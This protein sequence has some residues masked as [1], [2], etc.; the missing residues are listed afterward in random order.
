MAGT[1]SSA[2][3]SKYLGCSAPPRATTASMLFSDKLADTSCLYAVGAAGASVHQRALSP[4]N[5]VARMFGE[6]FFLCAAEHPTVAGDGGRCMYM[7]ARGRGPDGAVSGSG[8]CDAAVRV[9]WRGGMRPR[10]RCRRRQC[11]WTCPVVAT[12]AA[13][14]HD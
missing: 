12:P 11:R 8:A 9:R 4:R 2:P 5:I 14:A 6:R 1:Y 13:R 10:H 3:R 7:R